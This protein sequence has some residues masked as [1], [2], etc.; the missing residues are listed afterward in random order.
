MSGKSILYCRWLKEV[1]RQGLFH[2]G[3]RV[4]VAVSGGPDSVLLL[5]FMKDSALEWGITL[6]AVH[7]NHHLRGA[8]SD[9]DERFVRSLAESLGIDFIPGGADVARVARE[10][11][12]NLEA[13]ARELRYRFFLTLVNQGRLD[14]VVTAH[15]ANDQAETVLLRLLRGAGTRGLSGILPVLEG[16]IARPFLDLTRT[17]IMR[18]IEARRLEYRLDSSN[19]NPR[20]RRNKIRLELLPFL[21]REFNP[22][23]V[24]LLKH[25]ADQARDEESFLEEQAH[26]RSRPWRLRE[27]AG[28]KISLRAFQGFPPA[29]QRRV[30]RQMLASVRE[31]L[32][33]VSYSHIE[34][35]LRFAAGAQSGHSFPLPGGAVARKE[36]DWLIL[37]SQ[38]ASVGGVEYSY[39]L[40][41][42]GEV[43]VPPLGVT[44]RFKIVEPHGV[45]K[46]YNQ[47]ESGAMDAQKLTRRL[48]LRNWRAG[49]QFRPLGSRKMRKLKELFRQ[50]K[51]PLNQRRLWPVVVC[52]DE[53][54]WVRGFPPAAQA[55]ASPE[56]LALL[57]LEEAGIGSGE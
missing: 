31:S 13:T 15:N 46:E 32:R 2:P 51:I 49:D 43:A 40:E 17:E 54:V 37:G 8:E 47:T 41:I 11:K 48:F 19:L 57:I 38:P 42:P 29:I 30:L 12:R 44:F 34:G 6:A 21:E 7:F 9:A 24:P 4:G 28:E 39:P 18:E 36:F 1:K 16:K 26:E 33:G 35:L 45:A 52:G 3:Q 20:L 56:S 10:K 27:G 53:I 14:K 23:I 55:A 25:H 22:A 5:H 50:Q